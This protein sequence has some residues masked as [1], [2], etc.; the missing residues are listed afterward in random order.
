MVEKGRHSQGG[1]SWRRKEMYKVQTTF[2]LYPLEEK[3]H[4]HKYTH[5][6]CGMLFV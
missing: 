6:G 2:S 3:A 5:T 1:I 4:L